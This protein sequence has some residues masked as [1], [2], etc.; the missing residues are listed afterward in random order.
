MEYKDKDF[1]GDNIKGQEFIDCRFI[2]CKFAGANLRFTSFNKCTFISCDLSLVLFDLTS[3]VK[4]SFLESKLSNLDFSGVQIKECDFSK[5][6]MRGCVLQQLKPGSKNEKKK[7]NLFGSRFSEADLSG[8]VFFFCDLKAV[9]FKHANLENA[10][11]ERCSLKEVSLISANICGTNFSDSKMENT[12]L[13]LDGFITFGN[14]KGFI[15]EQV[16]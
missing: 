1:T 14:S 15:L 7:F 9:D 11:F 4:C 6:I 13:D 8:V 10:V 5:A 2:N 12:K 3:F 16:L